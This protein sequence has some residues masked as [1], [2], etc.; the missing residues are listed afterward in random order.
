MC[1]VF[2]NWAQSLCTHS[3]H[4]NTLLTSDNPIQWVSIKSRYC[5][6]CSL[7][8]FSVVNNNA[9]YTWKSGIQSGYIDSII[10]FVMGL[11]TNLVYV[12]NSLAMVL[13]LSSKRKWKYTRLSM[14]WTNISFLLQPLKLTID[15]TC[16][17]L[18]DGYAS[19]LL[20]PGKCLDQFFTPW[21]LFPGSKFSKT[22]S[23]VRFRGTELYLNHPCCQ[24]SPA[25]GYRFRNEIPPNM[26]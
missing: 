17:Y 12:L 8:H 16:C 1:N 25:A 24:V 6:I 11:F 19:I 15:K 23:S 5:F 14:E 7:I 2:S 13:H 4:L 22:L 18:L 9:V 20:L 10:C 26:Q 21:K 3:H